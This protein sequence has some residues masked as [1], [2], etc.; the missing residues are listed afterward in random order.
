[1]GP[2]KAILLPAVVL[3]VIIAF[4]VVLQSFTPVDSSSFSILSSAAKDDVAKV[5]L[6][7]S[8]HQ[9]ELAKRAHN[10]TLGFGE[11]VYISMPERSDRQDAMTILATSFGIKIKHF[12]GVRGT[13]MSPKAMPDGVAKKTLPSE[14]GCWRAH[15]NAWRYLLE[16]D[17]DTLLIFEDDLD[18]NINLKQTMELLSLQMQNS[19][20][21]LSEPSDYERANAPY[22][23]DWDVLDIGSCKDSGHPDFKDVYQMWD[24]PDVAGL[25]VI[26]KTRMIYESLQNFGLTDEDIGKKR[27]LSPAYRTVC[28]SAYAITRQGAERLLMAMSYIEFRNAVDTDMSRAFRE[29]RVRGYML[30]PPAISQFRIGGA[31]DTDNRKAGDPRLGTSINGQG[32][33]HGFSTNLKDSARAQMVEKMQLNNWEDYKRVREERN[34]V[35]VISDDTSA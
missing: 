31:K 21:R 4:V 29:G 30:T 19:K 5:D 11:I 24:D 27:L 23:L 20:I 1:M 34:S 12:P 8:A 32:N 6:K 35:V 13:E 33:L 22:G 17:M 7:S 28:T 18:W 26:K 10:A 14:I 25:D 3:T 2:P 15:A 9:E 16:S